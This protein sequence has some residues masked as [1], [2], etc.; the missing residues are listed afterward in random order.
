MANAYGSAIALKQRPLLDNN[1]IPP[2]IAYWR[3]A[4]INSGL[5]ADSSGNGRNLTV[6][7]CTLVSGGAT[8]NSLR[9]L[10]KSSGG[11]A[12]A[13]IVAGALLAPT[14]F[15]VSMWAR[16]L[17]V[18][19]GAMSQD[20]FGIIPNSGGGGIAVRASGSTSPT[21]FEIS[22]TTYTHGD[23][24]HVIFRPRGA[25]SITPIDVSVN[26]G[27][28][29]LNAN[30][31]GAAFSAR[32]LYFLDGGDTFNEQMDAELSEI[33]IWDVRL[34]DTEALACY[35]RGLAGTSLL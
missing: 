6:S 22:G 16:V 34:S 20:F 14:A 24:I 19:V 25:G 35:T 28:W 17:F 18:S 30:A 9:C 31:S 7:G 2:P 13:S 8:G 11:V 21:T 33:A 12:T 32:T 4:A 1:P 29:V 27:T 26:G 3:M 15:T 23:L 10:R 5:V